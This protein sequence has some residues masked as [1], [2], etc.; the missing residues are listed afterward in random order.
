M[1]KLTLVFAML[2]LAV[3]VSFAQS[4]DDK[5]MKKAKYETHEI[6]IDKVPDEVMASLKDNG[7]EATDVLNI[8]KVKKEDTKIY[9]FK[10]NQGG[11]KMKYKFDA[12]GKLLHKGAWTTEEVNSS[13]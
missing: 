4:K 12:S 9:K 7:I 13:L 1:K 3:A 8:Y 2:L 11:E 5:A 6:T 10:V